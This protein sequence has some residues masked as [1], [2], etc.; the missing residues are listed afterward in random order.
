M[1]YVTINESLN[2]RVIAVEIIGHA[3]YAEH[4]QDI[5]CAAVSAITIGVV[6][7]VE[8]LLEINLQVTTDEEKGLFQ[9]TVPQ[10]SEKAVDQQLQLM[11]R[12]L[13]EMLRMVEEEYNNFIKIKIESVL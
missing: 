3:G 10:Q 5:V 4:G 12:T 2:E 13:I 9:W 1:I 6:N 11:M 8:K 7:S